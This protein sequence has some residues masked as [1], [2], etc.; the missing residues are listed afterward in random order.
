MNE[1]CL[2]GWKCPKCRQDKE[3]YVFTTH[4]VVLTD[5]GTEDIDGN[6]DWDEESHVI[7]PV[8]DWMGQAGKVCL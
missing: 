4:L 6:E 2:K 3:F 5:E 7:C 8:C 1:N